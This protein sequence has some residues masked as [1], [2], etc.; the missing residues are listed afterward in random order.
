MRIAQVAPLHEAV[1]PDASGVLRS[2]F[3]LTEALVAAGHEVTLF[4]SGDS[5]TSARLVALCPKATAQVS[6]AKQ[7]LAVG[8]VTKSAKDFDVLHWH[9]GPLHFPSS[10][11]A[12]YVHVTTVHDEMSQP[13]DDSLYNH[14]R[15]LPLV[16]VAARQRRTQPTAGWIDTIPYGV[17][18][19]YYT[20]GRGN[21]NY[22]AAIGNVVTQEM[23][24]V[25]TRTGLSLKLLTDKAGTAGAATVSFK[26]TAERA[27]FL[28]D[29]VA[30]MCPATALDPVTSLYAV[31][32]AACGAPVIAYE[33]TPTASIIEKGKN[34]L[35]VRNTEHAADAVFSLRRFDRRRCRAYFEATLSASLMAERYV[36]VYNTVKVEKRKTFFRNV[37]HQVGSTLERAL[38][39]AATRN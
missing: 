28:S 37:P 4:A 1:T 11:L 6:H 30:V 7:L 25:A 39:E 27:A 32:A 26:T 16:A 22:I 2:I 38:I 19:S 9:S 15:E 13:G 5:Q 23:T 24:Q 31:E 3:H 14:F 12:D 36:K 29:A 17:S 33:N 21:G 18:G 8:T 34:G 10:A 20:V 35:I